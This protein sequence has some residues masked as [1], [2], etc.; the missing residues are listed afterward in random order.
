M[1][2]NPIYFFC[3]ILP[4][5][6]LGACCNQQGQIAMI[7]SPT[8]TS[9]PG[10]TVIIPNQ[11]TVVDKNRKTLKG[12]TAVTVSVEVNYL[13]DN[14]KGD[15]VKEVKPG[16]PVFIQHKSPFSAHLR[17]YNGSKTEIAQNSFRSDTATW[18]IVV[19]YSLAKVYSYNPSSEI[20]SCATTA[21]PISIDASCSNIRYFDWGPSTSTSQDARRITISDTATVPATSVSFIVYLTENGSMQLVNSPSCLTNSGI[22]ISSDQSTIVV[23]SNGIFCTVASHLETSAAT[24]A[25]N[26]KLVMI[27]PAG[28]SID[29][30]KL[31]CPVN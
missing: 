31:T 12:D 2:V 24:I 18:D 26:Q 5:L 15:F 14:N 6:I 10:G 17:Y 3:A 11:I 23:A 9:M 29:V 22:C 13:N 30:K 19:G 25:G 8:I 16:E 1:Q 21:T 4:V 20:C 27:C 28:Y 7:A